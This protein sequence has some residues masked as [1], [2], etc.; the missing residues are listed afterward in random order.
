MKTIKR[1]VLN[2]RVISNLNKVELNQMR[3]GFGPDGYVTNFFWP[4]QES[5]DMNCNFPSVMQ[6]C[7][8]IVGDCATR[9][10]EVNSCEPPCH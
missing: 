5:C 2:K 1:L 8:N 9:D 4:M 10:Y 7:T 3:A 6:P